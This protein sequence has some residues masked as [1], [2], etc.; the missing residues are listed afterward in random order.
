M[1][2]EIGRHEGGLF[3]S[4]LFGAMPHCPLGT[5]GGEQW[6][7]RILCSPNLAPTSSLVRRSEWQLSDDLSSFSNFRFWP[8]R[9]TYYALDPRDTP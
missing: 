4:P 7:A 1:F 5:L 3:S 8:I 6:L 2:R 9:E